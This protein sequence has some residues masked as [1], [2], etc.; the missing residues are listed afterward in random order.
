MPVLRVT[1]TDASWIEAAEAMDFGL[2][3]QPMESCDGVVGDVSSGPTTCWQMRFERLT[4]AGRTN[5]TV[6]VLFEVAPEMSV[7]GDAT[8]TTVTGNW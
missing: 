3:A 7:S 8:P 2:K 4:P 5:V 1:T 6:A